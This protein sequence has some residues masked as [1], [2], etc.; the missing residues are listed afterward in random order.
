MGIDRAVEGELN[1]ETIDGGDD[2]G[3]QGVG[4]DLRSELAAGLAAAD[5]VRDQI[6]IGVVAGDDR[7]GGSPN[8]SF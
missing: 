1:A 7:L 8:P 3:G 2:R 6:S 4:V 5:K